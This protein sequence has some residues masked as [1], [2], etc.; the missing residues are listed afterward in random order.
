MIKS[1]PN[2]MIICSDGR[3]GFWP[4]SGQFYMINILENQWLS[5][6]CRS[7]QYMIVQVP[8]FV[9]IKIMMK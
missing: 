4:Q 1:V 9:F 7:S 5:V 6:T 8:S 2:K 3:Y